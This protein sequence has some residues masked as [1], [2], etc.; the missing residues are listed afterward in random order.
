MIYRHSRLNDDTAA[1]YS[2]IR[3]AF[4]KTKDEQRDPLGREVSK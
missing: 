1:T 4:L 3:N 2:E